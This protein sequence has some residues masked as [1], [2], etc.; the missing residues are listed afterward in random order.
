[1]NAAVSLQVLQ[2]FDAAKRE[3]QKA[4]QCKPD[5]VL[6]YINL[7]ALL[8][9]LKDFDGAIAQYKKALALQPDNSQ[10]RYNLGVA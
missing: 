4:I 3:Y 7:G 9:D 1:M 5:Y 6:A 10:A 8:D 2:H